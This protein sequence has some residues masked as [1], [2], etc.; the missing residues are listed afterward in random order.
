MKRI[1]SEV[2]SQH[3]RISDTH[4]Q[5]HM[6]VTQ[7]TPQS[8]IQNGV[9]IGGRVHS[10]QND[11]TQSIIV[12]SSPSHSTLTHSIIPRIIDGIGKCLLGCG[13]DTISKGTSDSGRDISPD[14]ICSPFHGKDKKG[15]KDGKESKQNSH[16]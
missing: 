7:S 2:S 16:D 10:F 8:I 14:L 9:F 3:N 12:Y 13:F 11:A 1:T 6:F 4:N 15:K 5:R